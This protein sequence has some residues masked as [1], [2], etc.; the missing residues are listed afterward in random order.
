M[1]KIIILLLSITVLMTM[2]SS[3]QSPTLTLV[4]S[5]PSLAK[6]TINTEVLTAIIQSKQE[7]IEQRVFRN[8]I[9]NEFKNSKYTKNLRNFTTYYY[10]YNLMNDIISGKN[11]TAITKSITENS[12]EFACVLGLALYYSKVTKFR[13]TINC[14]LD[15]NSYSFYIP[16]NLF[17]KVKVKANETDKKESYLTIG[18]TDVM[19]F[20]ILIDLCYDVMLNN[21]KA[22]D[23]FKF[24]KD[25]SDNEFKTWYLTDNAYMISLSLLNSSIKNEK[26]AKVLANLNIEKARID[27]LRKDI[28]NTLNSLFNMSKLSTDIIKELKSKLPDPPSS[29]NIS[30]QNLLVNLK[31]SINQIDLIDRIDSLVQSSDLSDKDKKI[32]DSIKADYIIFKEVYGFYNG[33]KRSN[34]KDFT[35]TK[36]QFNALKFILQEFSKLAKNQYENNVVS[37]IINFLLDNS[38]VEFTETNGTAQTTEELAKRNDGKGYLYIDIESLVTAIQ[39]KFMDKPTYKLKPYITPFFSVGINNAIFTNNNTGLSG[40]T[41]SLPNL[42]FASEKLGLKW[43]LWNWKYTRSFD[44]GQK[45]K[46]FNITNIFNPWSYH[47]NNWKPGARHWYNPFSWG[48]PFNPDRAWLSPRPEPLVSDLHIIVYG[49]GLLYNLVSLKSDNNFNNAILGTGI[50]VTFY[51]GLS[52]NAGLGCPYTN[53]KFDLDKNMFFNFGVD[54]P[55][56]EYIAALKNK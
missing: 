5:S 47:R 46:Y 21:K 19:N 20:N 4:G 29:I 40:D 38:I 30:I 45:Y 25:T 16:N 3:G 55:I 17:E 28:D 50:G 33:L 53:N 39:K 18:S 1:K 42:S 31:D 48:K 24:Q 27:S 22:Q 54:I 6:G 15:K 51:N 56:I 23:K 44:A 8:T 10:L 32:I 11:K 9:I 2:K 14:M 13:D 12:A 35:L 41:T 34:F 36:S 37:T 52:L 26:D 7:Q 43:K 49:S